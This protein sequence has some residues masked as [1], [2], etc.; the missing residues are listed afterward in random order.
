MYFYD[1][2]GSIQIT[3]TRSHVDDLLRVYRGT[4]AGT[5][6][7]TSSDPISALGWTLL[8]GY[9]KISANAL[10]GRFV[11]YKNATAII[12]FTGITQNTASEYVATWN[13]GKC[14]PSGTHSI[15]PSYSGFDDICWNDTLGTYDTTY[16]GGGGFVILMPDGNG[17]QSQLV[18]SDGNSTDNYLLVDEKPPNTSDYVASGTADNEDDYT[19][20]ALAGGYNVINHVMP[21]VYA[22]LASAGTG[23][24]RSVLRVGGVSY[25][26]AADRML[27]TSYGFV[28][29]DLRYIDPS[30]SAAWTPTKVNALQSGPRV[31]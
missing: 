13:I 2:G 27:G 26:D 22:A 1:E 29:G 9:I 25:P 24:V 23:G 28:Q 14:V 20:S 4:R 30:D 18:G 5:L 19:L 31:R 17:D 21:I 8:R 7:A 6:L 11:I 10:L 3:V 15:G 12:D 16:P